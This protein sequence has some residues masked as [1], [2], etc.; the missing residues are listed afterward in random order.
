MDLSNANHETL[1][2]EGR[3]SLKFETPK[4]VIQILEVFGYGA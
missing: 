3:S 1:T 2:G 4:I